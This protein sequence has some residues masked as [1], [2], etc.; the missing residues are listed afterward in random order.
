MWKFILKYKWYLLALSIVIAS[1][2]VYFDWVRT[3]G[4]FICIILGLFCGLLA[5]KRNDALRLFFLSGTFVGLATLIWEYSMLMMPFM[6]VFLYG[7]MKITV[8]RATPVMLLG[9]LTPLWIALPFYLYMKYIA[10]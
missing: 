10:E 1:T 9:C 7:P 4:V 3:S 5:Y 6:F 8:P 2:G